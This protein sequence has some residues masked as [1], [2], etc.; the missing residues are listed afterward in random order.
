VSLDEQLS[1]IGRI[2]GGKFSRVFDSTAFAAETGMEALAKYGDKDA[3]V[4]Y[5][6]TTNDWSVH[7]QLC[8]NF[9]N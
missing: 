9:G 3:K 8:L 7:L 2:T 6:A 5:F 4:K 1:E